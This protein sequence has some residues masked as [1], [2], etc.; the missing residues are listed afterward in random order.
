MQLVNQTPLPAT[1]TVTRLSDTERGGI[2]TAKATFRFG[3][4]WTE[5][6]TQA[7]VALSLEPQTTALGLMPPDQPCLA[8]DDRFEVVI[9]GCAHAP[10]GEP[11]TEMRVAVTVG[12][13]RRELVVI[14]D[15]RWVRQ[16]GGV[17]MSPPV[18]FT[19]MPLTWERAFGGRCPIE[20][21]EGAFVVI[22]DPMNPA[23]R[24]YDVE[25]DARAQA[26]F[27]GVPAGFPRYDYDRL[28]PN[29]ERPDERITMPDDSPPPGCWA[30]RPMDSGLR[31]HH[32]LDGATD[33]PTS[34]AEANS[35]EAVVQTLRSACDEWV[36]EPPPGGA[37]VTLEGMRPE[38]EVSFPLP[39]LTV[40]A[41]YCMGDRRGALPLRAQQLLL[42]PEEQ[43]LVM[44]YRARFRVEYRGDG[45]RSMR[46]RLR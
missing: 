2:V 29:L 5:L 38:G 20:I 23:G 43:R 37:Q 7:P 46:L 17:V 15:R 11:V 13:V 25:R 39:R 10:G 22:A 44:T 28:L 40:Q 3:Q 30:T 33:R 24:G 12:D 36:I 32:I 21:D 42:L 31:A 34:V 27:L 45:E 18:P 14:G 16:H 6:D 26:E 41:D 4:G 35:L 8:V 1:V 9:L 19:H